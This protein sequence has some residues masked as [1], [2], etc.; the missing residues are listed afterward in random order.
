MAKVYKRGSYYGF[1]EAVPK[2]LRAIVGKT[3]IQHS[4]KTDS[5]RQATVAGQKLDIFYD[6]EFRRLRSLDA[7]AIKSAQIRLADLGVVLDEPVY[8][9]SGSQEAITALAKL[10][11]KLIDRH[12]DRV[13]DGRASF[14]AIGDQGLREKFPDP[15]ERRAKVR[16][17]QKYLDKM[18]EH[19]VEAELKPIEQ[20]Q[21]AVGMTAPK[22]YENAEEQARN[23]PDELS[24]D[25]FKNWIEAKSPT[26]KAQLAA[27]I[28]LKGLREFAGKTSLLE[29]SK[30]DVSGW[31]AALRSFPARRKP[32]E[33]ELTFNE[34][35]S[36]YEGRDYAPLAGKT[37]QKR[38]T[39][40]QAVFT[41][42]LKGVT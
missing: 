14:K 39:L 3:K 19:Q 12:E 10:A 34:V 11:S 18:G 22:E 36:R 26:T 29:I 8:T 17:L 16:V 30:K 9:D 24:N 37:V 31:L 13:I 42:A 2:D 1:Q 21:A 7:Q 4:L 27:E 38:F 28:A 15:E 33:S 35:M 6:D 32:A 20:A 5:Q 41:N 40:A 23:S 25:L